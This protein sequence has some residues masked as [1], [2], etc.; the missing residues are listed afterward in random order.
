M[1]ETQVVEAGGRSKTLRVAFAAATLARGLCWC[2]ADML[3]GYH[4]YVHAGLSSG[5]TALV[6]TALLVLGAVADLLVGLVLKRYQSQRSAVL[7]LQRS[8]A[9][10]AA[11]ALV[12]LF[13]LQIDVVLSMIWGGAF[14]IAFA[15]YA[16]PQATLLSLLPNDDRE[17]R[18]FVTLYSTLG[19]SARL[20]TAGGA[21]LIAGSVPNARLGWVIGLAGFVVFSAF[22]LDR[23][24]RSRASAPLP[25]SSAY[26]SPGWPIGF[27]WYLLALASHAGALFMMS[28][29]LLFTPEIAGQVATGPWMTLAWASGMAVGPWWAMRQSNFVLPMAIALTA[30]AAIALVSIVSFEAKVGASLLYGIGLGASAAALLGAVAKQIRHRTGPADVLAFA[31]LALNTKLAMAVGNGALAFLLDGYVAGD[32]A[33]VRTLILISLIGA[34]ICLL[35]WL[36]G[37]RLVAF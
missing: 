25:S 34:A 33:T 6:L 24:A 13:L 14:R 8:G 17:Q 18:L 5:E 37:N 10:I 28:R 16:V 2:F 15:F 4:L 26:R 27:N 32:S 19:S 31:T 3:L 30:G 29:L 20:L 36:R 22:Y 9:V 23:V 7:A 12:P 21:F 35:A 1:A 11:I